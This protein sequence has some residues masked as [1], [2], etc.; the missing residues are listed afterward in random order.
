MRVVIIGSGQI[1][2]YAHLKKQIRKD[3]YIIC[4]DGGYNHAK[5]MGIVPNLLVG[6]FDSI[7]DIPKGIKTLKFPVRKDETDSELALSLAEEQGADEIL[8]LGFTGDRADHML[9]NILMLTRYAEAKILD[10]KNE[11]FAFLGE[12]SIKNRKGKT[13]SIIPINGDIIGISTAG[14]DY[15]LDNETL[16]FGKSRGV[17][18]VIVS[19]DCTIKSES[20][21]GI[22]VINNGE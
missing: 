15:P 12:V 20:G 9:N 13:L 1:N 4:A 11:I 2:D 3:D 21:M 10:D 14:L 6:D 18:N 17:S 19:D 16:Y 22:I 8:L 5:N 7:R